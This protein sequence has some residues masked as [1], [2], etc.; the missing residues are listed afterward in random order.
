MDAPQPQHYMVKVNC[1]N[2][3][4][5]GEIQ[6]C[7]EETW[8]IL[9]RRQDTRNNLWSWDENIYHAL[10][11]KRFSSL[12]GLRHLKYMNMAPPSTTTKSEFTSILTRCYVSCIQG[13]FPTWRVEHTNGKYHGSK[14]LGW[15]LVD[16]RWAA[17]N[18]TMQLSSDV[19]KSMQLK[20]VFLPLQWYQVHSC[21]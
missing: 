18:N 16:S 9:A 6:S 2:T 20:T 1:F 8:C 4:T 10:L 17:Q 12:N 7:M 15:R 11:S 21:L 5:L 14:R 3:E 19:E 13:I